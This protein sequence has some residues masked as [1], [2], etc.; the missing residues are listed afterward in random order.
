MTLKLDAESRPD[1][2]G[3]VYYN[4][5][6]FGLTKVAELEYSDGCYQ[7]DTRVVWKSKDGRLWTARDSGCSCPSPFESTQELDRCFLS[8]LKAEYKE[9]LQESYSFKPSTE[10]FKAFYDSVK[11]A[12][13]S[14]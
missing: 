1:G 13:V 8:D 4:P 11:A 14:E 9:R 2:W 7:F 10:V 12:K 5:E 6:Q 3:N